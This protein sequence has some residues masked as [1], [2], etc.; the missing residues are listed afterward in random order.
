MSMWAHFCSS[1]TNS[2]RNSP[3]ACIPP[4]R[5]PMFAISAVDESN[6]LRKWPGNGIGH[7]ASPAIADASKMRVRK[8]A[9]LLMIADVRWPIAIT[10][11]P[12]NVATSMSTSGFSSAARTSASARMSRPSA[13]V[14]RT[15]TVRP[16]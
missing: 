11:A 9:S 8:S 1:S 12:V 16:P 2:L 13:S 3:A 15:S 14:L 4:Y 5:P 6:A 10:A 7:I